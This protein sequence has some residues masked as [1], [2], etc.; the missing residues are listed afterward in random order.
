M[1]SRCAAGAE[2]MARLAI[3]K[4]YF[5]AY[6]ALPRKAQRKADE[7]LRKFEQDSAAATTVRATLNLTTG[8]LLR[9]WRAPPDTSWA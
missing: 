4:D 9:R 5:P 8:A 6:A 7:F 1:R 2:P 3:S